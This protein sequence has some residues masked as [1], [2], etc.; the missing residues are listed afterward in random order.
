MSKATRA[1]VGRPSVMLVLLYIRSGE[2]NRGLR[3]AKFLEPS[4]ARERILL[5]A[6]INKKSQ[7]FS[8]QEELR[9]NVI[10]PVKRG[11][12]EN[13]HYENL[14]LT[15]KVP[16]KGLKA[17]FQNVFSSGKAVLF[18]WIGWERKK[19]VPW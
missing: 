13:R 19:A 16:L 3:R 8:L 5:A 7:T 18:G 17:Y 14:P 9:I 4:G 2:K 10:T 11:N 1:H 6:N 15:G 12:L